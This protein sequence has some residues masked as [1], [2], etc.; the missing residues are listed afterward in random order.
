MEPQAAYVNLFY[1][2]LYNSNSIHNLATC[3]PSCVHGVCTSTN[4][5]TCF[6]SWTGSTCGDRNHF[7]FLLQHLFVLQQTNKKYPAIC[8]PPCT[9][10]GTCTAPN[11]C[12]CTLP[13]IGPLCDQCT[14]SYYYSSGN[15]LACPNCHNGVCSDGFG[16]GSC[17]C[18][19]GFTTPPLSTDYC[20][21]CLDGYFLSSGSCLSCNP[22][23]KTCDSNANHCLRFHFYFLTSLKLDITNS[24]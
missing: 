6:A 19:Q 3:S 21:T 14:S 10:G 4:T 11:T 9:N 1:F 12:S 20:T 22:N 7:F 23:C 13:W 2:F 24:K 17:V 8:D 16:D 5:C 18:N 15:C